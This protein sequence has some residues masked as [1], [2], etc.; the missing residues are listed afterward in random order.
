MSYQ[1]DNPTTCFATPI[2]PCDWEHLWG[3]AKGSGKDFSADPLNNMPY[4]ILADSI[5]FM[6]SRGEDGY[7][8]LVVLLR[9][10]E[11]PDTCLESAAWIRVK[12]EY[13]G[14]IYICHKQSASA[15]PDWQTYV[16][17]T[18]TGVDEAYVAMV[19]LTEDQ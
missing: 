4:V 3:I 5:Y 16:A 6:R 17:I 9:E 11:D 8:T 13:N 10:D 18:S 2:E 7:D 19:D 15:N 1:P 14:M 12:H